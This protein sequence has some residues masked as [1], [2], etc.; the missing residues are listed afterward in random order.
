[1]SVSKSNFTATMDQSSRR[2]I[3]GSI[4]VSIAFVIELTLVP[5]ILPAI[6]TQFG[7]D[8]ST[9]AWVFN[10]YGISVAFGVLIGGW[11]GDVFGIRK[12]FSIGVLFFAS[13]AFIVSLAGSFETMI[14][15]RIL[16]G[17]GGGVFSPLVPLLLTRAVPHR[18]GK[19][20]MI[21][22]SI[23]GYVAAF[24]PLALGQTLS[25]T[26]WQSAFVLFAFISAIA[27]IIC[28][29]MKAGPQ[30]AT[31]QTLPNLTLLL[32]ARALWFV[33]GYVFCTYGSITF[34]LFRQPLRLAEKGYD[35]TTN[36]FI[37][38]VIWLSFSIAGTL[39]RNRVDGPHVRYIMFVA[40]II[41]ASGFLVAYL[42]D[43]IP[44]YMASA[45]LIGIGFAFSNAPSTQMVLKFAP[46]GM[47]AISTSL[48]ITFA[49]LG[50]VMTVA[51]LAQASFDTSMFVPIGMSLVAVFFSMISFRKASDHYS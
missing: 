48:D 10:S 23:V 25:N 1:M 20:L 50:G 36:G 19:I 32:R 35:L 27:L 2:A 26:G 7:W 4:A 15:G 11:L 18:P 30:H 8:I 22:G 5:L 29:K 42:S 16:Q 3:A 17:F 39:L 6:Q 34:Y 28:G 21:W 44:A 14:A 41:I 31:I 33:F 13:G 46:E 40:P 38:S 12:V 37:L 51:F 9:V 49:R 45:A 43:S 24:A 47:S